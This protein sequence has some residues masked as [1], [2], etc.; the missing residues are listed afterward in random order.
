M[1]ELSAVLGFP[2]TVFVC[3]LHRVYIQGRG[4]HGARYLEH[5]WLVLYAII[6][7]VST[8][9]LAAAL[10]SFGANLTPTPAAVW[11]ALTAGPWFA[12]VLLLVLY[13]RGLM[14]RVSTGFS[15]LLGRRG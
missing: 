8:V 15:R 1:L 5:V 6:Q 2:C 11:I 4:L 10:S 9:W 14:L 13:S 3:S 7:V 12:V